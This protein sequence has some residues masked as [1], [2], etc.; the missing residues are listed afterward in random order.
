VGYTEDEEIYADVQ[1]VS[2]IEGGMEDQQLEELT[3][4]VYTEAH[5][6]DTL[7]AKFAHSIYDYLLGE[8]NHQGFKYV[9]YA[10]CEKLR[11]ELERAKAT[12]REYAMKDLFGHRSCFLSL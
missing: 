3:G 11:L 12:E 4:I 10:E 7:V 2:E 1:P 9:K 8:T 5:H 6:L